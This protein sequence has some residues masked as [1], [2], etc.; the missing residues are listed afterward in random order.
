MD[1]RTSE[2]TNRS[3]RNALAVTWFGLLLVASSPVL[4]GAELSPSALGMDPHNAYKLTMAVLSETA[5]K[6]LVVVIIAVL[7]FLCSLYIYR[8]HEQRA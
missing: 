4:L 8:K 7:I 3:A 6:I 5:I 1:E 2:V